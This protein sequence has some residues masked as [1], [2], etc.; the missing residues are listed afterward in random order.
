MVSEP[1][2]WVQFSLPMYFLLLRVII[3]TYIAV[4]RSTHI[5][6]EHSRDSHTERGMLNYNI[7]DPLVPS[8]SP[9]F[10]A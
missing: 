10:Y 4:S 7:R 8:I 6:R 2:S 3:L 1:T 9:R 5:A